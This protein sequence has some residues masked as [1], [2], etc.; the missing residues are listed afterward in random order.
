MSLRSVF[1]VMLALVCGAAAAIAVNRMQP[2]GAASQSAAQEMTPVVVA[3]I[4]IPR[5]RTLAESDLA[6][7]QWPKGVLPKGV[8]TDVKQAVQRAALMNVVV[9]EPL[10]ETKLASKESGRGLAAL[11]PAGMRAYTIQAKGVATNVAGFVLPGNR[12]DVLLNLRGREDDGSGGGSTTTLLQ[13]VE[14][15]A[16]G[17][18]LNAPAENRV[19]TSEIQSVTLLVAPEQA[20]LLDLGQAAGQLSLSL[21]N[22]EDD[23]EARTNPAVLADIRYRQEKPLE[24][25]SILP[26]APVALAASEP[27]EEPKAREPERMQIVTLRGAS[28][29]VVWVDAIRR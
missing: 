15:L 9:G 29:G 6:V 20:A 16:V 13:S 2:S 21:R 28:R 19:K 22:P 18:E 23:D 7:R 25:P 10:F 26:I 11:V 8:L 4:D 27:A 24:P 14:V 5:G 3:A 12:V 1:V 17:H